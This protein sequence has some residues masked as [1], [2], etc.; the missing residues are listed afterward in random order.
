MRDYG[1]RPEFPIL[2]DQHGRILD[3]RH[4]IA[5]A[6]KAGVA[7]PP[8]R[9]VKVAS[10]E[11]AVGLAMLVNIQ[12]GWT[13][14]NAVVL[15]QI[16][17]AAGLTVEN[18]GRQLG[19]AAKREVIRA[20]LLEDASRSDRAVAVLAGCDHK[21]VFGRLRAHLEGNRGNSP[22]PRQEDC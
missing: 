3:G 2:A 12:R 17:G 21:T 10:D 13:K 15:T 1:Y 6:R 5:A 4:R 22:L 14:P 20:A 9:K 8:P 11:E 19:T 7:V 18:F 16:S